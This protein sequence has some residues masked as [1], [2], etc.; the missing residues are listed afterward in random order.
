MRVLVLGGDGFC[1]WPTTLYLS[2]RGHDITIIDNLSRRKIDVELEVD[3]LTPIRPIG[4]RIQVWREVSGR[5]VGFINLDLAT[6]YDRLV[7]VLEDIQPDAI[8]HFAEQR[9]APYS[10]RNTRAKRYTVDNNVRAT[11][12]LLTA[13]V[14]TGIDA[15]LVH[16]GTMGVYG[17]GWSGSAPI[18]EGYL[19]VKVPTPDGEL[20]REILHPANPGSVYHLTK[21]LDQL[22]F[23]FYSKNDGLRIT[24][25]HQGIVWGTQT[26]QT[27]RDERLINRFDY[28]GDYGTVLNRFLMQAAIG[29]PLTVHGTGG[30]TRAFI[31]IRD[32]VRCIEIAITNPPEDPARPRVL[33]Q[34][35]ETHRLVD[36]AKMI[37][38]AMGAEIAYLPNPRREAEENDLVVRNEQFLA[39]GLNPTTLSEGLL[40]EGRDIAYRY[41]YRADPTKIIARSVWRAGMETSDDLMTEVPGD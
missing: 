27:G 33:N 10:M 6:E 18:P 4:E 25:L 12:N 19:T 1:G 40:E 14:A 24:D 11:H 5:E 9:A 23:S 29:H 17:Y 32:T 41:R 31:H 22:L 36:L 39:L 8:V 7:A 20:E 26:D 37:A 28:D 35:T 38:D 15:S 13:L 3:S 21:T 2:D 34:M 30:Q 16:L